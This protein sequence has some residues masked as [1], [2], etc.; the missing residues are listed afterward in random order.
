MRLR[1]KHYR[2]RHADNYKYRVKYLNGLS[3]LNRFKPRG[4][5]IVHSSGTNPGSIRNVGVE[6]DECDCLLRVR[7]LDRNDVD[8][9]DAVNRSPQGDC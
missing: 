8:E 5:H 9:R 2:C 1:R 3:C 4:G 7:R 6:C